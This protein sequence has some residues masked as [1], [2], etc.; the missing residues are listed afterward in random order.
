MG[1]KLCSIYLFQLMINRS[2]PFARN[3]YSKI[4]QHK[5][6]NRHKGSFCPVSCATGLDARQHLLIKHVYAEL[7]IHDRSDRRV[8]PGDAVS[9]AHKVC[10][11]EQDD[12]HPNAQ[13]SPA[14]VA[15]ELKEG[16]R[17]QCAGDRAGAHPIDLEC[18]KQRALQRGRA[19]CQRLHARFNYLQEGPR[20]QM[21]AE[22][23]APGK[24][25]TE[26]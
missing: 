26:V 10:D 8:F 14:G 22:Q 17:E 6:S 13:Q 16:N 12:P 9:I 15:R 1:V 20:F 2:H 19:G 4:N 23:A 18:A 7:H 3:T 21:Q 24:R 25:P 11:N 5:Q